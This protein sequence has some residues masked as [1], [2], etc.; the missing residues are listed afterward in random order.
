MRNLILHREQIHGELTRCHIRLDG[1]ALLLKERVRSVHVLPNGIA[2][3]VVVNEPRDVIA[4]QFEH[5]LQVSAQVVRTQSVTERFRALYIAT[6]E[7]T[8][9]THFR[10]VVDTDAVQRLCERQQTVALHAHKS[11]ACKPVTIFDRLQGEP[12]TLRHH[13]LE[14][15]RRVGFIYMTVYHHQLAVDKEV[16]VAHRYRTIL[17]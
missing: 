12:F 4:F 2:L 13:E 10:L 7:T 6:G 5:H 3:V 8:D 11:F 17:V 14:V 15:T 9:E 1:D 16:G